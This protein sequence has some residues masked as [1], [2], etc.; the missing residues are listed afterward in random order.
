[1]SQGSFKG[2]PRKNLGYFK[3]ISRVFQESHTGDSRKIEGCFDGVLSGIHRCFQE[4]KWVFAESFKVV[5]RMFQESFKG[6]PTKIEECS[7]TPPR[8]LQVSVSKRSSKVFQVSF[9]AVSKSF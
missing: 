5:S 4:V 2:V 6:V 7:Q 3:E 9:K 1:M 8:E